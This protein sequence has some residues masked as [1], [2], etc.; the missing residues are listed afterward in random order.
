MLGCVRE[1]GV[2]PEA[3]ERCRR[4]RGATIAEEHLRRP[5]SLRS[6]V[7]PSRCDPAPSPERKNVRVFDDQIAEK[8][9]TVRHPVRVG[10]DDVHGQRRH[11]KV[12][13]HMD[14]TAGRDMLDSTP[15]RQHGYSKSF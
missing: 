10:I 1:V 14:E 3:T 12:G 6:F 8:S 7:D 13:Q 15:V 4:H 11:D 2:A 5:S 9:R